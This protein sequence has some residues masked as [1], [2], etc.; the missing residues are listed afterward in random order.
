MIEE[1]RSSFYARTLDKISTRIPQ[2]LNSVFRIFRIPQN[3]SQ[4]VV[5][6]LEAKLLQSSAIVKRSNYNG[7]TFRIYSSSGLGISEL[8]VKYFHAKKLG[9]FLPMNGR[10]GWVVGGGITVLK[11]DSNRFL[12]RFFAD[13]ERVERVISWICDI[14]AGGSLSVTSNHIETESKL[15]EKVSLLRT[16]LGIGGQLTADQGHF[17][18]AISLGL[19][20]LGMVS[21]SYFY[22]NRVSQYRLN[23]HLN[24]SWLQAGKKSRP[25]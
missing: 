19:A 8:M 7:F 13:I 21:G 5:A 14:F 9:R 22:E 12:I 1:T 11:S 3:V 25:N 17:E 16:N 10:L 20:P 2:K 24:F 18:H 23:L 4:F 15:F 6:D